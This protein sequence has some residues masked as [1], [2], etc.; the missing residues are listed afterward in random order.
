MTA[1]EAIDKISSLTNEIGGLKQGIK[2]FSNSPYLSLKEI[3]NTELNKKEKE[4][5]Y[6]K[7]ILSKIDIK[8]MG[9]L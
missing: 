4:L 2:F 6:L 5:L 9:N 8:E 1:L 3:L 7:N